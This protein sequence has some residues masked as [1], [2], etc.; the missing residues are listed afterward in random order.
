MGRLYYN[1]PAKE[2]QEFT[3]MKMNAVSDI[4][5]PNT[6]LTKNYFEKI[7]KLVPTEIV[8]GYIALINLVP[9][10]QI[11][12]IKVWAY[13]IIFTLCLILTP[14][15][16]NAFSE[17]EKPK[18]NH[19]IISSVAF[20]IWAYTISGSLV[21]PKFYDSSLSSILLISF[22]LISGIIPLKK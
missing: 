4:N 3:G 17:K 13:S 14:I 9:S 21:I 12:S 11:Q 18:R 7:A 20:I 1:K 10:I 15:Y 22:S 16:L 6:N 19:L 2:N 8:A 5:L